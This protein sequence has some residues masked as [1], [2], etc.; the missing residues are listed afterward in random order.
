MCIIEFL[1]DYNGALMV[2]IT[3]I[4][5]IATIV[6]CIANYN[7][8]KATKEQLDESKR[9][10]AETQRLTTMPF[11]YLETTKDSGS[12]EDLVVPISKGTLTFNRFSSLLS[13]KNI[14]NGTATNIV[15]TWKCNEKEIQE[16]DSFPFNAVSINSSHLFRLFYIECVEDQYN[17]PLKA[18]LEL[19]YDDLLGHTYEQKFIF[20]LDKE[21]D[22][23]ILQ[24]CE[25]DIPNYK[26]KLVYSLKKSEGNN[27]V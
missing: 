18:I 13:L 26:G 3:A 1:N 4:Y 10:F 6:I 11:L 22:G 2:I 16:I 19:Q 15:Y 5:V 9:Q 24:K 12:C 14:G 17:H 25:I 23:D 21:V 20:S 8:A 27:H 7:S